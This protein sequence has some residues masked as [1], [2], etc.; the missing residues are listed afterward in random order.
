MNLSTVFSAHTDLGFSVSYVECCNEQSTEVFFQKALPSIGYSYCL[1][2]D[3]LCTVPESGFASHVRGNE[4]GLWKRTE[5]PI[6]AR[7]AEGIHRWIEVNFPKNFTEQILQENEVRFTSQAN[8]LFLKQNQPVSLRHAPSAYISQIIKQMLHCPFEGIM[9]ES[10]LISKGMELVLE[11]LNFFCFRK[12]NTDRTLHTRQVVEAEK[13]LIHNMDQNI[14][15]REL[16]QRVGLSESTLKRSFKKAHGVSVFV[17]FQKHRM[18]QARQMLLAKRL[19]VAEVAYA[20]G[21]SAPE[22][23]SRAFR[24]HFGIP[25]KAVQ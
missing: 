25:P 19:N 2:G 4:S 10:Y 13:L 22:H 5:A 7:M 8:A 18:E 9:R 15:I 11:E 16:A 23:F 1:S 17:F 3:M 20:L 12:E 6:C 21:Y 24:V 14:S